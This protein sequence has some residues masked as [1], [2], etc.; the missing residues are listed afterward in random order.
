LVA[1]LLALTVYFVRSNGCQGLALTVFFFVQSA[2][3]L[4]HCK[5][6]GVC[7]THPLPLI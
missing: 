5:I 2:V 4:A 1:G 7:G 6:W 3:K